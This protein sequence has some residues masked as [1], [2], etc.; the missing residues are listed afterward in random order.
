MMEWGGDDGMNFKKKKMWYSL[1]SFL[2]LGIGISYALMN[3]KNQAISE[4]EV[5]TQLESLY[6]AEV[7]DMV[8]AKDVYTAVITKSGSAY[9]VEVNPKNG[10]IFSMEPTDELII[11]RDAH[12]LSSLSLAKEENKIKDKENTK[13]NNS[14][15]KVE[16]K[17]KSVNK[18]KS[19]KAVEEAKNQRGKD[20]LSEETKTVEANE[21]KPSQEL[22]SD[23]IKD[24]QKLESPTNSVQEES[25]VSKET[26]EE[27]AK[28][29]VKEDS[30]Q[31][32]DSGKTT[33]APEEVKEQVEVPKE[34]VGE[35]TAEKSTESPNSTTKVSDTVTTNIKSSSVLITEKRALRIALLQYKGS[36]EKISFQKTKDGGY[37]LVT[38][39]D[40][41]KE[42]ESKEKQKAT[43]QIHAISGKIIS[44]TWE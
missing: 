39:K 12:G 5:R 3:S 9:R 29:S 18:N 26:Q 37:Y 20:G 31:N 17:D 43:I 38:L 40:V 15:S 30:E 24:G 19:N 36:F 34:T 11:K 13:K 16:V 6:G 44:V 41:P 23:T 42:K 10:E 25:T 1:L 28:E 8:S 2:V 35:S 14:N 27:V 22:S 4:T 21:V 32:S 33:G 7:T